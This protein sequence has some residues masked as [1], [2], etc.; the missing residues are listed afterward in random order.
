MPKFINSAAQ[1][2]LLASIS[3]C[4]RMTFCSA[5]PANYA[6]IAAVALASATPTFTGPTAG[7]PNGRTTTVNAVSGVSITAAGTVAFIA[8]DDGVTLRF[9][10]TCPAQAV[11]MGGTLSAAAF[12]INISDPA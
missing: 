3:S 11:T 6:G 12:T 2:A 5:Q 1:D 10:D 8:L 4:T 9:V 7:S